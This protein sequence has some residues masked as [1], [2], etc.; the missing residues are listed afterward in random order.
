[1]TKITVQDE[2]GEVDEGEV[3][4]RDSGVSMVTDGEADG[5][6]KSEGRKG[7]GEPER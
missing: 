1:M 3:I 2:K 7:R 4:E 5:E 6:E